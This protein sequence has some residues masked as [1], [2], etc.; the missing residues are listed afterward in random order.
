MKRKRIRRVL[1]IAIIISMFV[2]SIDVGV[3]WKTV[4]AEEKDVEIWDG[5]IADSFAGGSGTKSDPY[6]I[7][8]AS[9]LAYVSKCVNDGEF[10]EVN[11]YYFSLDRDI[12]LN[13]VDQYSKWGKEIVPNNEWIPIGNSAKNSS[14]NFFDSLKGF[15]LLT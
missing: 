1:T 12:Y 15:L 6:V 2:T 5:T 10:N 13:K 8:T 3:L 9:E 7:S 4:N 11:K 14:I